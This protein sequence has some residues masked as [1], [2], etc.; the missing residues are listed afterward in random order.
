[1]GA[2]HIPL[3]DIEDPLEAV[4]WRVSRPDDDSALHA[5]VL[6]E[7]C[8]RSRVLHVGGAGQRGIIATLQLVDVLQQQLVLSSHDDGIAVARALQGRPVWAAALLHGMRV[9]F[10][11]AAACAAREGA[12]GPGRSSGSVPGLQRAERFAIQARWPREIYRT[13]RRRAPRLPM[14]QPPRAPCVRLSHGHTLVST[15]NLR[16]QDLSE[17]GC[18][19]V[20]PAGMVPPAVGA[21]LRRVE[22]ELDDTQVLL[23]DATVQHVQPQGRGAHRVGLRWQSLSGGGTLAL[24]R[25]LAGAVDVDLAVAP[26]VVPVVVAAG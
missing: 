16:V 8:D 21:G 10:V 7:L 6:R 24:R 13:S 15:R 11:L 14:P 4:G 26:K 9:Q 17:L 2:A 25:W 12:G 18:A 19:V 22:L 1:M 5:E 20:L 23:A 3:A